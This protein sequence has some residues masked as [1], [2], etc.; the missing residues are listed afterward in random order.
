MINLNGRLQTNSLSKSYPAET[1]HWLAEFIR[2][3]SLGML[4]V[5]LHAVW[6]AGLKLPGHHGLEWMALI[7]IGRQTS[8]NRWAASTASLGAAT[9]ALLP[10]FGFDDPFIWLIYLVPGLLIDLAYATPAKWQNQIVWVALLGGLA[11]ASKPLLRLGIN[12]LT[13]WPY[14]SIL[15]GIVYPV[16]LH[17]IFGIL[18]AAAGAGMIY[19]WHS[20][21]NSA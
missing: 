5:V 18:G 19:F 2:L 20:R 3:F 4:V 21:K 1:Q 15:Y 17:L 12:L 8:Q 7:I 13:G 16:S 14:G 11:H 6:R 10:I 9:T